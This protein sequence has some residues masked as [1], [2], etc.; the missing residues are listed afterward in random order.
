MQKC[1]TEKPVDK[2]KWNFKNIILTQTA[3][4]RQKKLP[5]KWDKQKNIKVVDLNPTI[6]TV[7]LGVKLNAEIYQ[8]DK[9]QDSTICCLHL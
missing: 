5:K 3:A 8:I 1:V 4:E 6:W 7:T 2:L 9:K